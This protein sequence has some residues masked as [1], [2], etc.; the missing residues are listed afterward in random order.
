[1]RWQTW[2]G[3]SSADQLRSRLARCRPTPPSGKV[4]WR[5]TYGADASMPPNSVNASACTWVASIEEPDMSRHAEARALRSAIASDLRDAVP[6][7]EH[8]RGEVRETGPGQRIRIAP[9]PHDPGGRRPGSPVRSDRITVTPLR[10]PNASVQRWCTGRAAPAFGGVAP[11]RLVDVRSRRRSHWR[12]GRLA[13]L[14]ALRRGGFGAQLLLPGHRLHDQAMIVLQ[15]LGG[16]VLDRGGGD[17]PVL[18]MSC[19]R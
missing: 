7:V 10:E 17:L 12:R 5:T 9:R 8:R 15:V 1:M 6:S 2:P 11:P 3:T 14:R 18:R 19:G 4:G 16:E 13:P